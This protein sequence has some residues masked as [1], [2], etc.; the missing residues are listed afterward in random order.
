MSGKPGHVIAVH[1]HLDEI[2]NA[3]EIKKRRHPDAVLMVVGNAAERAWCLPC[4]SYGNGS[5]TITK[6]KGK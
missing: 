2:T 3:A 6:G 5:G 4:K 1:V